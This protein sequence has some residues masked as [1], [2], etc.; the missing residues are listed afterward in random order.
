ML[1]ALQGDPRD[2]SVVD[3]EAAALARRV[4]GGL[5]AVRVV[6]LSDPRVP[7]DL[8]PLSYLGPYQLP[9]D[10]PRLDY[11]VQAG[12]QAGL[13]VETELL[14]AAD[15]ARAIV[16]AAERHDADVVIVEAPGDGLRARLRGRRLARRVRRLGRARVFTAGSVPTG[17][18]T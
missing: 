8:G 10:D 13:T 1:L 16:E 5:V 2:D 4:G 3:Q 7:R 6:P 14:A 12:R 15:P 9:A 17:L 18:K 11:A